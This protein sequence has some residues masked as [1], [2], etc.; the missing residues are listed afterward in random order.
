LGCYIRYDAP[1]AYREVLLFSI[2]GFYGLQECSSKNKK[3]RSRSRA[4]K[5]ATRCANRHQHNPTSTLIQSHVFTD[6]RGSQGMKLCYLVF[7]GSVIVSRLAAD[8]KEKAVSRSPPPVCINFPLHP[9]APCKAIYLLPSAS[10]DFSP[11]SGRETALC[12][13]ADAP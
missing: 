4:S 3:M 6:Y 11:P 12:Y 5:N 13:L 10:G 9:T 8:C 2:G 7:V 1:Q